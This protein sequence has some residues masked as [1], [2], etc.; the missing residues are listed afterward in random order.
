MGLVLAS[1]DAAKHT[2]NKHTSEYASAPIQPYQA[3]SDSKS[4]HICDKETGKKFLS[5]K[6]KSNLLHLPTTEMEVKTL[7]LEN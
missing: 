1:W 5:S 7:H 4:A 6:Y 2:G 3:F